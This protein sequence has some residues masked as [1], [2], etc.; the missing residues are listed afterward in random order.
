MELYLGIDLGGSGIRASVFDR[1]GQK[2]FQPEEINFSLPPT[3]ENLLAYL[4]NII[5]R[6]LSLLGDGIVAYGLG[7][8]GPLNYKKGIIESPPNLPKIRDLAVVDELKKIFPNLNGFLLNDADAALFGESWWGAAHGFC[9]VVGVFI[10]TGVGSAV[11]S[12]GNLQR[13]RGKG[14]EWGHHT[15]MAYGSKLVRKCSCGNMN[16]WE[17]FVGTAGLAQTY[18][19]VFGVKHPSSSNI[20][21]YQLRDL[22]GRSDKKWEEILEIYAMNIVV[23]LR[24]IVCVHHPECIVLGGGIILGNESLFE[25]ITEKL[26]AI[27]RFDQMSSLFD[28]L[29][30]KTCELE[31]SGVAGAAAYAM[32][33]MDRLRVDEGSYI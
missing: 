29:V 16:C 10:G 6:G 12:R 4:K 32:R 20:I 25:K 3:N 27:S 7:S 26:H 8:P 33:G 9:D 22:V 1:T 21:S 13:G 17:A 30:I 31:N 19:E 2:Q 11:M 28:G 14:P 5:E 24:N 23:G 15:V 18:C